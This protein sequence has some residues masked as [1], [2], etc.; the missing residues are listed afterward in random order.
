MSTN[1]SE[2][3]LSRC[4]VLL[5]ALFSMFSPPAAA[6]KL[7]V[8]TYDVSD[9]LA[10][11]QVRCI[12]RDSR[13]YL[14]FCTNDGLSWFDGA[15]FT[16]YDV[17][18]GLPVASVDHLVESRDGTYWIATQ[19]GG[20]VRFRPE[21][22]GGSPQGGRAA[23]RDSR[24]AE[25]NEVLFKTYPIGDEVPGSL[26]NG[27][28][29]DRDGNIWAST[30]GGLFRLKATD[31]DGGSFQ[32]V[33]LDIPPGPE[34]LTIAVAVAQDHEGSLWVATLWGVAR[35]LPTGQVTY[36]AL[37][38]AGGDDLVL[39]MIID[40]EGRLWF[41][42]QSGLFVFKPDPAAEAQL[43]D[44]Q[45][46]GLP[47][48]PRSGRSPSG[49]E[50]I[51]LPQ[52]PGE[53]YAYTRADG[54]PGNEVQAVHES[55]DGHVWIGTRNGGVVE[56]DGERFRVYSAK[57]G[58]DNQITALA[59]DRG[60]D[61][62]VGTPDRGAM[63]IARDGLVS[64][65][66]AEG[67]ASP[68][69]IGLFEGHDGALYAITSHWFI[70]RFDGDSFTS[71][72]P[73]L[74]QHIID[75][76]IGRWWIIQDRAGEWWVATIEGLYRFPR[77]DRLED[78]ALTRP[79]A[80]Y[81]IGDGLADNNVNRLFEDSRGDIWISSY[82][83]PVM[84]TRWERSTGT[85]HRYAEADGLPPSNWSNVFAEDVSG[86]VWLGLHNGGLA[87]YRQGRFEQF[88]ESDGV[89]GGMIQGLH[90]D[91]AGSLWVASSG[92]GAVRI[93][94]PGGPNPS[95]RSFSVADGLSSNNA[96]SFA[97]DGLGRT[98]IGTARGVD[99]L[100]LPK[101]RFK[102]YSRADGLI[103]SEVTVAFFDRSG[104][105]WFGM[106]DGVS[107]L[108][109]RPDRPDSAPPVWIRGIQIHGIPQ[110]LSALGEAN[111][112][113][114]ELAP[115]QSRLQIEVVSVS[116]GLTKG[117]RY[118][119]ILEGA[120]DEWSPPT[121]QSSISYANLSPGTYRFQARA[122]TDQGI[123]SPTPASVA[124]T[125]LPPFWQRWWFLVAIALALGTAAYSMHRFQV[126]RLLEIQAVRTR[127]ATDLHDDIGLN[128]SRMV[129]LSEVVKQQIGEKQPESR[130]RLTE[131][132][133]SAR[134]LVDSMSDIVWSIDPRRD[135]LESLIV[136]LRAFA[137][138][139]LEPRGIK[140]EFRTGAQLDRVR[141]DPEK[142]R[143][144]FLILKEAVNN[145][146]RHADCTA[147]S[148][149]LSME[150]NYLRAQIRD[151][152]TGFE[153][154]QSDVPAAAGHGLANMRSR[155]AQLDGNLEISSSP[156]QG[157]AVTLMFPIK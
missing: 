142:R 147:A 58:L 130:Q 85:F 117:V 11:D 50:A 24:S 51:L 52:T 156:G 70:N 71:I 8:K 19:G 101:G 10:H 146:A 96:R 31:R 105:L 152:G 145:I 114:F 55:G 9:G 72:Q 67:I 135:D 61:L 81:T 150:S 68:E 33:A 13:G 44:G 112:S 110:P 99:R 115:Q 116:F 106:R 26:V 43:F 100:D 63:K 65:G 27:V 102:H 82:N 134:G 111:P 153:A 108:I 129:I 60:G 53:A 6:Q 107:L 157:T 93:D 7:P 74:P 139:V 131:I 59:E 77:V 140:W 94:D 54:L 42:H 28:Y 123:P 76:S 3:A 32:R 80:H 56:F 109:P 83:P 64:Y 124:F 34:E 98:Y 119:Y 62:W 137:S 49:K 87:R 66:G 122:L 144:L 120:D 155:A 1:R 2:G 91:R 14:W 125:V 149:A 136:R 57:Q 21:S 148:L 138:D 5:L 37:R 16:T 46:R 92:E 69:T 88:D 97:Q 18:D 41:A 79:R 113:A 151:D 25:S 132:A 40:R 86:Q 23:N 78:L 22:R 4:A 84:L 126:R 38:P 45:V 154:Q 75:S 121:D 141:L 35:L 39:A 30:N 20:V 12:V 29:E 103:G 143:G 127:I 95:F 90:A 128:L 48:S 73:N 15:R 36:Y 133:E 118:E 47:V 104:R 17:R 89:P